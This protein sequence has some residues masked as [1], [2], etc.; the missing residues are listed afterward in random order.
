MYRKMAVLQ[1]MD[2]VFY[3]AQRQGRFSFYMTTAGEEAINIASAAALSELD[4]I[5]AQV[6]ANWLCHQLGLTMH[7]VTLIYSKSVELDLP[8]MVR[9]HPPC[10]ELSTSES[11]L[12]ANW[13][14]SS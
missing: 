4:T 12:A 8:Q 1:S 13:L 3:D 5:F 2:L 11:S 9:W 6:G 14:C 10:L 7:G